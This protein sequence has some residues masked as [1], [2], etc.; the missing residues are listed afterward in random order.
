M[1]S[2][3]H[4]A[5]LTIF[6]DQSTRAINPLA[7]SSQNT[8]TPHRVNPGSRGAARSHR[9][10]EPIVSRTLSRALTHGIRTRSAPT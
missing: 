5:S 9:S 6:A 1:L 7:Q 8:Y 3:P 2:L 10:E 4:Q